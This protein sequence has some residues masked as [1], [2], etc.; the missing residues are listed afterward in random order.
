VRLDGGTVW[1]TQRLLAELFQVSVPSELE[2]IRDIR[3][4]ENPRSRRTT[5]R[6][7]PASLFQRACELG[8]GQGCLNLSD[9]Y[10]KG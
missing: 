5:A 4:S 7:R 1:L 3:A 6:S 8:S 9:A 10:A 2:R